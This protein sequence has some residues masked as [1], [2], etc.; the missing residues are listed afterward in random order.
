MTQIALARFSKSTFFDAPCG[1]LVS[2]PKRAIVDI[3]FV[4]LEGD[5]VRLLTAPRA[6][7]S[8]PKPLMEQS[9]CKA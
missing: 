9:A 6:D 5:G 1:K 2:G 4:D 3:V 8:Y 7:D